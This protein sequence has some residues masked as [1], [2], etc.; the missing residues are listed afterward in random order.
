M[1]GV[2]GTNSTCNTTRLQLRDC[3]MSCVDLGMGP[4]EVTFP[5]VCDEIL[6]P[7]LILFSEIN[8]PCVGNEEPSNESAD[9]ADRST[10]DKC[11]SH[12]QSGSYRPKCLSSAHAPKLTI[13]Y[14]SLCNQEWGP[15]T[16]LAD[17]CSPAVSCSSHGCWIRFD[18]NQPVQITWSPA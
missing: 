8:S 17:R 6:P 18:Q 3:N 11:V 13:S 10:Y 14:F 2:T 16:D 15:E 4:P 5:A 9:E 7:F 1:H 12:A